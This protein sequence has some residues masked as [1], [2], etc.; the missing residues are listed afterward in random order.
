MSEVDVRIRI[1]EIADGKPLSPLLDYPLSFF[2]SCPN[3]GDTMVMDYGGDHKFYSVSRR[4]N[5]KLK[6]WAIIVRE[7]PTSP[8]IGAVMK[9]WN[10]DDAWDMKLDAQEKAEQEKKWLKDSERRKLISG[11][12]P[13]EFALDYWE[14]P[15]IERLKKI[16]VG[17]HVRISVIKGLGENTRRKLQKRGFIV[18]QAGNAKAHNDTVA[19]T[20]ADAKAW[21][22]LLAHR[23][24]VEAAKAEAYG[25]SRCR[26]VED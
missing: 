15:I 2:G 3:V 18:V 4:Y 19:L 17:K 16:G 9:A 20:A 8:Q 11:K 12:T 21:K 6:G 14:E 5:V 26:P 7:V 22:S 23:K 1:Y 25:D 10:D 13:S 24:K